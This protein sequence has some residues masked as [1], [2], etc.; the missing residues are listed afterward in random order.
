ML[1]MHTI[2]PRIVAALTKA[3]YTRVQ[4][5]SYE[6]WTK[7]RGQNVW[8]AKQVVRASRNTEAATLVRK[9]AGTP[10]GSVSE[11]QQG[12]FDSWYTDG[13]RSRGTAAI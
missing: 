2:K 13:Y 5:T 10:Q 4:Q 11:A 7:G 3:G 6:K 8:I 1:Q 9:A 12:S